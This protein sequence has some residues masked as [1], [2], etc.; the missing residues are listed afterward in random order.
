MGQRVMARFRLAKRRGRGATCDAVLC[1]DGSSC[2]GRKREK[3]QARENNKQLFTV[4]ME[5]W[6][7]RAP[8]PH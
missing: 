7:H 8:T 6:A 1:D 3:V 4:V 2:A 5:I